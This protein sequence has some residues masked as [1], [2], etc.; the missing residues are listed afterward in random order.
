LLFTIEILR[1]ARHR[2]RDIQKDFFVA[3]HKRQKKNKVMALEQFCILFQGCSVMDSATY[4]LLHVGSFIL[5]SLAYV[6]CQKNAIL[7]ARG[8]LIPSSR[9]SRLPTSNIITILLTNQLRNR[10]WTVLSNF[11]KRNSSRRRSN[12]AWRTTCSRRTSPACSG[13]FLRCRKCKFSRPESQNILFST[14]QMVF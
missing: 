11:R 1:F 8:V 12:P 13:S 14:K 7:D 6:S 5:I 2:Q 10:S 4:L 9:Y 3:E